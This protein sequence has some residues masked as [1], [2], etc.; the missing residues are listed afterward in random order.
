MTN[1]NEKIGKV[2]VSREVSEILEQQRDNGL[3]ESTIKYHAME[4]EGWLEDAAPLNGLPLDTLIRALYVGYEIQLTPEEEL[5]EF[6]DE[7][8]GK[9]DPMFRKPSDDYHYGLSRGARKAAEILGVKLP[10]GA[11]AN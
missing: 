9:H 2:T 10:E 5:A 8:Y 3:H 6:I 4:P 7:H 11:D 1:T